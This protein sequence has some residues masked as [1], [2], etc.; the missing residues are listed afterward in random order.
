ML[1]FHDWIYYL[2]E[3]VYYGQNV[4][5]QLIA[6]YADT[7]QLGAHKADCVDTKQAGYCNGNRDIPLKHVRFAE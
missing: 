4:P 5:Q 1:H 6:R 7:D 3:I 2:K